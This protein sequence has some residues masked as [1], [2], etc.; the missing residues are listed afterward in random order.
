MYRDTPGTWEALELHQYKSA[1]GRAEQK[2]SRPAMEV[3]PEAGANKR[4]AEW[5]RRATIKRSD[6]GRDKGVGVAE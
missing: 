6:S 3:Q 1:T 4:T 5:Y 2:T